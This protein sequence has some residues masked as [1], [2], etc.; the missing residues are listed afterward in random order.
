MKI[1]I[2]ADNI[3]WRGVGVITHT[4]IELLAKR[5]IDILLMTSEEGRD[6]PPTVDVIKTPKISTGFSQVVKFASIWNALKPSLKDIDLV[7]IPNMWYSVVEH[8]RR[9]HI[10]SVISVTMPWPVCYFGNLWL[11]HKPCSGCIWYHKAG[12]I[13]LIS[14]LLK[15]MTIKAKKFKP[16]AVSSMLISSF[17]KG[18]F[19]ERAL[20]KSDRIVA[21]SETVKKWLTI[22]YP[23]VVDKIQVVHLG[24]LFPPLPYVQPT[25]DRRLRLLYM[26]APDEEK[27]IFN[28][29]KAFS[30][31]VR[32]DNAITLTVLGGASSPRLKE[33]IT[34]LGLA[35]YVT[36]MP[37][38]PP[39][40][41]FKLLPD[42]VSRC[43][44]VVVPSLYEDAWAGVTT[45]AM[46]LGRPVLV[47]PIGGLKEQVKEGFN[48]YYCD[49]SNVTLF[50][51]KILEL[52]ALEKEEI[53]KA[54]IRAREV[55]SRTYNPVKIIDQ[56]IDVFKEALSE[57]EH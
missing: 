10:P 17:P 11:E 14:K 48:G 21:I 27:G 43:D 4:Q 45:Q 12:Q 5:G 38:L 49:C 33:L 54:G 42:I 31:A 23:A 37:W 9:M 41:Y 46:A 30:I 28:L 40:E 2:F 19:I 24:A 6:L 1:A 32:S 36:L 35:N 57:N 13:Q 3:S 7:Y 55:V 15:C 44:V 50:A 39:Q 20:R 18:Y 16:V 22:R 53:I 29:I 26:S 52:R 34:K 47:N 56:L 51:R 8:A 25:Q